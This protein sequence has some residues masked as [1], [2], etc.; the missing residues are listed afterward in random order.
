AYTLKPQVKVLGPKYGPLVQKILSTFRA[1]DA[2]GAREAARALNE[3]GKLNF[4]LDGHQI[5]LTPDEIEVVATARPGFVAAGDRGYVVAL[6]T[7]ITPDLREEGLVRDLTHYVQDM[8][9][10]AGFNIED[11]IA[12]SLYTG[13]DLASILRRHKKTLQSETL[14]GNLSIVV[15]QPASLPNEVYREKISPQE[16]KKLENYTVEVVLGRL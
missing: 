6:E 3:T 10:R 2:H 9:K 8:R 1:L 14:A 4:T 15:D 13:E 7:T 11:H 5:E 12:L 16:R